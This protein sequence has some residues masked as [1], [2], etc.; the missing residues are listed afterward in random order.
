MSSPAIPPATKSKKHIEKW[1]FFYCCQLGIISLFV[2]VSSSSF[3]LASLSIPV[4][5]KLTRDNYHLWRAQVLLAICKAQLESFIEGTEKE[6]EKTLEMEKDS[7]KVVI[8]NPDH[9]VW[10]VRDQHVLTYLAT[11][12]SQEVLAGVA[13]NAT[14][15]DMWAVISKTF[16]SQ[17]RSRVLP[18]CNQLVATK[19]GDMLVTTYFSTMHGYADEMAAAGKARDDDDI[20]SY[21]LNG[22]D[23]EYNSLIEHVNGMTN[24]ISPKTLYAHLLD[25]E[26]HLVAQKA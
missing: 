8:P 2:V 15:T 3:V 23:A 9:A 7:R 12:L 14:T 1:I 24:P 20:V 21:I 19:K 5:E 6:L 25:T 16:A 13:S 22:L 11:S 10:C 26:A 18:L 17:S 4:S